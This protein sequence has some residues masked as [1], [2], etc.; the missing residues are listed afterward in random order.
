MDYLEEELL[1][2][3]DISAKDV[4]T[5]F[6]EEDEI[7]DIRSEVYF[8]VSSDKTEE[9]INA[10]VTELLDNKVS[11]ELPL[12]RENTEEYQREVG[13][14]LSHINELSAS[15][16]INLKYPYNTDGDFC[17]NQT[18]YGRLQLLKISL[19]D[20]IKESIKNGM[21]TTSYYKC[22][23]AF[24]EY[25]EIEEA[26]LQNLDLEA[27]VQE[28]ETKLNIDIEEVVEVDETKVQELMG[29]NLDVI[30]TSVNKDYKIEIDEFE[31]NSTLLTNKEAEGAIKA[32]DL[33]ITNTPRHERVKLDR[34]ENV[35]GEIVS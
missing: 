14:I 3:F 11:Y 5:A 7:K 28:E 16:L 1:S 4:L 10:R 15:I 25:K 27:C 17:T 20:S 29:K 32:G 23:Q 12:I 24:D 35:V 18:I 34:E 26:Y 2:A 8:M 22:K 9:D 31:G 19:V 33:G 21:Y 6:K 13:F 30:P